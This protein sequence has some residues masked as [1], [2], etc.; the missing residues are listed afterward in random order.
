M[1]ASANP[2]ALAVEDSDWTER[3]DVSFVRARLHHASGHPE[4][5]IEGPKDPFGIDGPPT[6]DGCDKCSSG[7]DK[8]KTPYECKKSRKPVEQPRDHFR[9]TYPVAGVDDKIPLTAMGEVVEKTFFKGKYTPQ[10]YK[11]MTAKQQLNAFRSVFF[12]ADESKRHYLM[13]FKATYDVNRKY[14]NFILI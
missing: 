4:A 6:Y 9:I 13:R 10:A 3:Y 7:L 14:Y 2:K 5:L 11:N 1:A 8:S 12:N